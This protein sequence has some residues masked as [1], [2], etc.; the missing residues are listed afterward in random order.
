MRKDR[1]IEVPFEMIIIVPKETKKP[2]YTVTPSY[3][4]KTIWCPADGMAQLCLPQHYP[5]SMSRKL[6]NIECM[7]QSYNKFPSYVFLAE[8]RGLE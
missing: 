4:I 8:Q 7:V 1:C 3:K 2:F 5:E 6:G